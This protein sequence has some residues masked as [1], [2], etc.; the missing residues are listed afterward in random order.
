MNIS[1][2]TVDKRFNE[3][4]SNAAKHFFKF[5][6][7]YLIP[8]LLSMLLVGLAGFSNRVIQNF[9]IMLF[10]FYFSFL[11]MEITFSSVLENEKYTFDKYFKSWKVALKATVSFLTD[12]T[13]LPFIG[14]YFLAGITID[15]I[16]LFAEIG[17]KQEVVMNT[18]DLFFNKVYTLSGMK[19][20]LDFIFL[21][22]IL[23]KLPSDYFVTFRLNNLKSV[24][25]EALYENALSLNNH[26]I[27][28]FAI[29]GFVYTITSPFMLG[30][31]SIVLSILMTALCL[32]SMDVFDV[33]K[34]V[35]QE[36][37][38]EVKN[39]SA[40]PEII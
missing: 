37:E 9:L 25:P 35:R 19:I 39:V 5:Q 40:V 21:T 12:R 16:V 11:Y 7:M 26:I 24:S 8:V 14:I 38:Q 28:R 31:Q 13:V 22:F 6:T 32:Y 17:K 23:S 36:Q 10:G 4:L 2:R 18:W 30:L 20:V 3:Y 33:H 1:P 34:G 29:I 27:S 15:A